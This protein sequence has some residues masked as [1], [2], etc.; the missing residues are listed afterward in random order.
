MASVFISTP[1]EIVL[2]DSRTRSGTVTLPTTSQIAYRVVSFKDQYGSFSNS[3]FTL[4]TQTGE[5]FDDGTTTKTFSNAFTSLNLYA[6]TNNNRWMVMNGTQTVQQSI[7]SLIVNQ[8][9]FGTGAGWVQFGPV[10]ATILSS[11]QQTTNLSFITR[12][13]TNQGNFS[14]VGINNN[15]PAYV[16]DVNGFSQL[17]TF[18]FSGNLG[19]KIIISA[20]NDTAALTGAY[21]GQELQSSEYRNNVDAAAARFTWGWTSGSNTFTQWATLSNGNLG[22]N[23]NAPAY[24]MDVNGF[25][26]ISTLKMPFVTGRKLIIW[27]NDDTGALRGNYDGIEKQVA[28]FRFN[29]VNPGDRFSF[30]NTTASN[31]FTEY[32]RLN[33]TR[34]GLFC[35]APAYT[36]DVNGMTSVSTLRFPLAQGRKVILYAASDTAANQGAYLGQEIQSAEFRNTVDAAGVRFSWGATSAS[37][38]F[39]EWGR[40]V[41]RNLQVSSLSNISSA[42]FGTGTGWIRT[43]ALQAIALSSVQLNTALGY[44][45]SLYVGST[46]AQLFNY[47]ANINGMAL[48]SSLILGQPASLFSTTGAGAAENASAI[49][50]LTRDR[51]V[52]PGSST[53]GLPSDVRIKQNIVNADLERCYNDIRNV[54]LRRFQYISSY[55]EAIEGNDRHVLGFIAQ[56][57][58]SIIPKTV[59]EQ[60]FFGFPNFNILNIDQLN[61]ALYGAVKKTMYDKEILESTVKGQRFEIQT[62]QGT[63]VSILSTLEGLQGR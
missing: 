16:L 7:S 51:A 26:Q 53:W 21:F 3:T 15:T 52:K 48:V 30:G 12:L 27:A 46:T 57:V 35:N 58:S 1:S 63:T 32:M 62:L 44:V 5:A 8:L 22:I 9:I 23:C 54:S 36:L 13:S 2:I 6:A 37:N 56:E 47:T 18:R 55:Y 41:D 38:T 34:L 59:N 29:V 45:S 24:T 17:S 28:D 49:L 40:L 39:T 25:T 4:S 11:I 61:M 33:N 20:V 43:G 42:L 60:P 10:Q 50:L 31:T 19:R 14:S